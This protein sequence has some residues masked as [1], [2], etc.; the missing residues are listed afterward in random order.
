[1]S[2]SLSKLYVHIVFRIK[3]E[4]IKIQPEIEKELY[5]YI[6][7]IIKENESIPTIINGV[8]DHLHVFCI[9]SKNIALSKLVEEIKRHSS[10]WIK[11]KGAKYKAFAWQGGYGGFSVSPSLHEKTKKYI[12]NQKSHHHKMTFKEEYILFLNEYGIEY[13]DR[14]AWTD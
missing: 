10:R 6:G 1:M 9:M 13:D 2:Q 7:S 5:A 3:K 4:G 8:Q 11:T 14:Y 12:Q